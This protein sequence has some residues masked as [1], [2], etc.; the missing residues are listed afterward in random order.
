MTNISLS[1]CFPV[2][3]DLIHQLLSTA[4]LTLAAGSDEDK[5]ADV[6]NHTVWA[7]Q[8]QLQA[9]TGILG[10]IICLGTTSPSA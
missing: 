10:T 8:E 6:P 2:A 3:F 4:Q 1:L 9:I 7:F 5:N